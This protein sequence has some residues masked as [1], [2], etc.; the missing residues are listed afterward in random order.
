M[1]NTTNTLARS[2]TYASSKQSYYTALLMVDKDLFDD[3]MRAYAYFRWA[4]DIVDLSS[5]SREECIAF[6]KHQMSLINRLYEHEQAQNL[7]PEEVMIADLINHD[8]GENSRLQSFIRNFMA[9]IEFDAHRKGRLISQ[10]ELEW[11]SNC[12]ARSVT[13]AIQYFIRNG[14]PFPESRDHYL[15]ATAAHITHMLRDM[16]E[17]LAEGYI[18]I[19]REYLEETAISPMDIDSP[20]FRNWVRERVA[21]ARNYFRD[22]KRYLD[23]LDVLRCKLAGYWYCARFEG[24]LDTIEQDGYLLRTEYKE[25]HKL[26]FIF[27]LIRLSISITL[28]H[29]IFRIRRRT[30]RESKDINLNATITKG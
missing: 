26:S 6:I 8:R 14:H 12:L 9:I 22:G 30:M 27:K 19:P 7:L 28:H 15:A 23:K 20:P 24:V 16:T 4:D 13:D 17:D 2:I 25:R 21:L 5:Q 1:N 29:M 3:C 10:S 18:N 11:Y